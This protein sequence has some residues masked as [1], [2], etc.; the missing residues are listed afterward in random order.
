[1]K[2]ICALLMVFI[3]VMSL[4]A[5]SS[6][7]I[8]NLVDKFTG[9]TDAPK[10]DEGNKATEAVT[11][12]ATGTPEPTLAPTSTPTPVPT[13][14][15]T[16]TPEPTVTEE[17]EPTLEPV[18]T[19][20]VITEDAD[21]E[22]LTK[23]FEAYKE[24]VHNYIEET[25]YENFDTLRYGLAFI[26]KDNI[27]ELLIANNTYHAAGV[28]VVFYNGGDLK[29]VGEFGEY[30]GFAYGKY[31][32]R[33][34]SYYMGMG[35]ECLTVAHV[36]ENANL[37][38]DMY[39]EGDINDNT[40]FKVNEKDVLADE[41]DELYSEQFSGYADHPVIWA[42][43]D[44]LLSFYPNLCQGKET[45]IFFDYYEKMLD[46]DFERYMG[47][48]DPK[49][50]PLK[51]YWG[52][53]T[54]DVHIANPD[55]NFYYNGDDIDDG[56]YQSDYYLYG[57][58]II[59][60]VAGFWLSGYDKDGNEVED[61][62]LT[63]YAMPMTY[64]DGGISEGVDYGWCVICEPQDGLEWE[65]DMC[66]DDEDHL[67]I[68][69]W[70]ENG[71]TFE[72]DGYEYPS[73]DS[74]VLTFDRVFNDYDYNTVTATITRCPE[75]DVEGKYAFKAEEYI[76]V[77]S[78]DT[79][80]INELGLPEDLDGYDYDIVKPEKDPYIFYIDKYT[81]IKVINWETYNFDLVSPEEFAENRLY[82]EYT[83]YFD[84]VNDEGENDGLTA[85]ALYQDYID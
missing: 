13:E 30:G 21:K 82:N 20:D 72:M 39:M 58:A 1:M 57:E 51:G 43:Y 12:V 73:Q 56:E 31:D 69:L 78:W 83:I 85:V 24:Y 45:D 40:Y 19:V 52:F 18:S 42:T 81:I 2:K 25:D 33:I 79:E 16:A 63:S 3:M 50:I 64:F 5:C 54:A 61:L 4:A 48:T 36:D 76:F 14:E 17:P 49:M 34:L 62:T 28:R 84:G 35:I 67:I 10:E 55:L 37:V 6:A 46:P 15:V 29:E 23:V 77:G 71:E 70:R 65:C 8:D 26:D 32:N 38:Q 44:T 53:K 68:V 7:D 41:F 59:D 27:P 11:P 47:F 75:K 74:I 66:L 80:L 60:E 22:L 9:T